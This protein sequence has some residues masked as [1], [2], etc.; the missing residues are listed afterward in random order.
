MSDPVSQRPAS[1]LSPI[2]GDEI[3]ALRR[4]AEIDLDVLMREHKYELD[5]ILQQQK[6]ALR[7]V[8]LLALTI[9]F[10]AA[11]AVF[12]LRS[13]DLE[14]LDRQRAELSILSAE[15]RRKNEE[16]QALVESFREIERAWKRRL[17]DASGLRHQ[18]DAALPLLESA[19]AAG[20]AAPPP[21][22]P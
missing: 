8:M 11:G 20:P 5:Q 14:S 18:E 21:A 7:A 15:L 16:A 12:W 2:L 9:V 10:L 17:L 22:T 4:R 13:A 6:S 3:D 19:P 1:G